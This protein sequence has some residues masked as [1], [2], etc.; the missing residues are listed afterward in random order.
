MLVVLVMLFIWFD[1]IVSMLCVFLMSG[2]RIGSNCIGLCMF[3]CIIVLKFLVVIVL[4]F[5][6]CGLYMFDMSMVV[7]SCLLL[8]F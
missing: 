6:V 5:L 7:L 2:S 1:M 8:S 4:M 3:V